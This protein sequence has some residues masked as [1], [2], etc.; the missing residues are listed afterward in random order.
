VGC[1]QNEGVGLLKPLRVYLPPPNAPM[2][3]LQLQ[4][5]RIALQSHDLVFISS[6]LSLTPFL[7]FGML[8]LC[9]SILEAYNLLF[10]FYRCSQ[11][12]VCL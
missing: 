7:P 10:E 9:C 4:D 8:T 6:I 12:R 2:L 11:L 5:S 1:S 3:G